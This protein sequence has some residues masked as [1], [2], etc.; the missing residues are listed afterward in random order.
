MGI[1][2]VT[3]SSLYFD[4]DEKLTLAQTSSWDASLLI[5]CG[6]APQLKPLYDRINFRPIY[7]RI[8][9]GRPRAPFDTESQNTETALTSQDLA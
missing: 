9:S 8:V 4:R 6:S 1:L 5:I 2:S 7:D 3:A